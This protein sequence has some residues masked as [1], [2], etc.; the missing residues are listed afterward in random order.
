MLLG[1]VPSYTG[2]LKRKEK[3]AGELSKKAATSKKGGKQQKG[4][5]LKE[6]LKVAEARFLELEKERNEAADKAK[7]T[8]VEL[9]RMQRRE[10]RKMKEVDGKAYQAGFDRAGAEYKMEARKM[11]NEAVEFKVPIAYRM[12]YKDGVAA[13]A[14]VLQLEP[15][16]NLTRSIP[17][18]VVPELVLPYTDEEC[19]PLPPEKFP[20]SDKEIKDISGDE[21]EDGSVT[22]SNAEHVE[23]VGEDTNLNAEENAKAE[24]MDQD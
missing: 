8:K 2:K 12:G 10:R 14:S 21:A 24:N 15:D 3:E 22:K 18:A 23:K 19:A 20:E 17:E 11:V 1:Y 13:A 9:G 7:K 16:L 4:G 5:T 6:S